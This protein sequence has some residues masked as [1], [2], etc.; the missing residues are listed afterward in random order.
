MAS[1]ICHSSPR[2]PTRRTIACPRPSLFNDGSRPRR[3]DFGLT[4]TRNPLMD[5]MSPE[6]LALVVDTV[7]KH[8][9]LEVSELR[10][11]PVFQWFHLTR[12]MLQTHHGLAQWARTSARRA[13]RRRSVL[14]SSLL[15]CV[16][17][18]LCAVVWGLMKNWCHPRLRYSWATDQLDG[19]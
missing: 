10:P 1:C 14:K 13:A 16:L 11:F 15:L 12:F 7:E 8:H 6:H 3:H 18:L 5:P 17:G 4:V 2:A 9:I 19:A